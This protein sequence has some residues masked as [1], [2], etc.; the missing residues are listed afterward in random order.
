MR[1]LKP[2]LGLFCSLALNATLQAQEIDREAIVKKGKGTK[3]EAA[4]KRKAAF[5]KVKKPSAPLLDVVGYYMGSKTNSDG[6]FE[7]YFLIEEEG[8][9]KDNWPTIT[10]TGDQYAAFCEGLTKYHRVALNLIEGHGRSTVNL[11]QKNSDNME[12][13]WDAAYER[14]L[15]Q[16]AFRNKILQSGANKEQV[17][18]FLKK[19][20]AEKNG[21]GK[22]KGKGRMNLKGKPGARPGSLKFYSIVIGRLTSKDIEL[23]E[24][25]IDVDYVINDK[26]Q[27]NA[28]LVGKRISLVGVSGPFLDNLLQIKRGETIKVRT[29]DYN[30]RTKVLG[31]GYKFQVL[32]RTPPF[33]PGD[34]GIPPREFR[35]FDGELVGIIVE[36]AGYEVL[37][38]V[39]ESKPSDKSK[40]ENP[41]S[42][43]GNRI[44]I[45][46]FYGQHTDAFPDLQEGDRIRVSVH[47]RSPKSDAVNVTDLLKK[48]EH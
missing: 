23:G 6:K 13:D 30:P 31:F 29:G 16:P 14:L 47:H 45:A 2:I 20:A 35:G 37:L 22:I 25:V 32:E 4:Q 10:F 44:R 11:E 34:F 40:A 3:A 46:G 24:M 17:I 42:I 48:V 41:E 27:F 12:K 28:E 9:D 33:N 8:E 15:K 19:Q 39:Q 7:A 5:R 36:A 18:E 1:Y 26:S 43:L 21:K 38:D